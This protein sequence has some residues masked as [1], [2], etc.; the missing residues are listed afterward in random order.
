MLTCSGKCVLQDWWL[1]CR[2]PK[3]ACAKTIQSKRTYYYQKEKK[4]EYFNF[5]FGVHIAYSSTCVILHTKPWVF[6]IFIQ[7][8][9]FSKQFIK[10]SNRGY[11]S[12]SHQFCYICCKSVIGSQHNRSQKS[13]IA[14]TFVHIFWNK[15]MK[16]FNQDSFTQQDQS[17]PKES[18]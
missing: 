13:F 2:V 11:K 14:P 12:S 15:L 16:L 6:S 17:G 10:A 7:A 9:S 8:K 5:V 1:T 18:N 3:K 4:R